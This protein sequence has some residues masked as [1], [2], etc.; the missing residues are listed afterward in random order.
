[1]NNIVIIDHRIGMISSYFTQGE[2]LEIIPPIW[3]IAVQY[4]ELFN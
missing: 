3:R 4:L 1:M 2:Y